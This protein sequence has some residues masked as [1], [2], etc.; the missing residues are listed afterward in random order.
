[1]R[2]EWPGPS[3]SAGSSFI[4]GGPPLT[5]APVSCHMEAFGC[6]PLC[7][8]PTPFSQQPSSPLPVILAGPLGELGPLCAL[9]RREPPEQPLTRELAW[10]GGTE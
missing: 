4:G 5:A 10:L 7:R 2:A 1:M 3:L 6:F 9:G 8:L